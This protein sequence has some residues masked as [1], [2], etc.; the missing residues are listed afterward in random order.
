[1]K[2]KLQTRNVTYFALYVCSC[3]LAEEKGR[4]HPK[5][6][7]MYQKGIY[8]T[9]RILLSPTITGE[10]FMKKQMSVFALD[11]SF[12]YLSSVSKARIEPVITPMQIAII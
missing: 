2:S 9:L 11:I 10:A 4:L 6:V 3:Y 7:I 12:V 8:M 5:I 1:M